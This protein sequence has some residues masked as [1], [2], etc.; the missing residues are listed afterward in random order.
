MTELQRKAIESD[1]RDVA[2]RCAVLD[3]IDAQKAGHSIN[4]AMIADCARLLNGM[5]QKEKELA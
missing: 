2:L 1:L 5:L 4:K 3:Y